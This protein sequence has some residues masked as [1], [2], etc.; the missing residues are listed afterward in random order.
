MSFIKL[1]E[2]LNGQ[3]G[4]YVMPIIWYANEHED[5]IGQQIEAIKKAG[6][7]EFIIENRDADAFLTDQW[8]N[9]FA[10]ILEKAKSLNMRVWLIDDAHVPTGS[11]NNSLINADQARFRPTNLRIE[12][13]DVVGPQIAGAVLLPNHTENEQIISVSAFQRDVNTGHCYGDPIDLR[14]CIDDDL[15][16]IDLEEGIWRIFFILTADPKIQNNFAYF[17]SMLSH[18]SCRQLVDEVY[19]KIYL[20]FPSYFGN[21]FAGFYSDEPAFGNCNGHYDSDCYFYRMG[22]T[23]RFY[24]WSEDLPELLAARANCPDQD[25]LLYLPALWDDIDDTSPMLRVA[26][27]AVITALWRDNFSRQIGTWC[28]AHQVLYIGHILEDM[29]AHFRTGF[30]CGHFFRSME[31]QHMAGLDLVLG[32]MIPGLSTI[33][34]TSNTAGKFADPKF[35]QYTLAKLGASLAHMTPSMQN[36]A[37]CEVFGAYGWTAG[38][39]VMKYIFHHFLA[40]G[41]NHFVPHAYAMVYPKTHFP[42][43]FYAEGHNPQYKLFGNLIQSVQRVCHLTADGIHK[44][45]LALFYNA[46]SEWGNWKSFRSLDD[47][48]FL[49]TR[50]GFDFDIIPSDTILGAAAVQNNRLVINQETYAALVLPMAEFLPHDLLVCLDQLAGQGLKIIFTDALPRECERKEIDLS[51]LLHRFDSIPLNELPATLDSLIQ[52]RSIR[53]VPWIPSLRFYRLEKPDGTD[54][55]LF[56]NEGERVIDTFVRPVQAGQCA[57]YDPWENILTKAQLSENGLRLKLDPHQLL[58]MIFGA[59]FAQLPDFIYDRPELSVLPLKF[60][61]YVRDAGSSEFRLFMSDSEAI[62]LTIAKHMT[63]YCGEFRYEAVFEYDNS[64]ASILEIPQIGDCAELSVNGHYCGAQ[65]G[66]VC[67]F[68]IKGLVKKGR[69][70]ISIVTAD[71]PSYADRN[72]NFSSLLPLEKHGFVGEVLIG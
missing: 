7:H 12:M 22:E 3:Y 56:A 65:I 45:D 64:E 44:A 71:N 49:L 54:L 20:H 32:Q 72:P 41:V 10:S 30:G 52:D 11:A 46:E 29:G 62:N 60:D 34:N 23:Q 16:F 33:K 51:G 40:N 31:G 70:T 24:P 50:S 63:R 36:R 8:C 67:R 48:T 61:I 28:E 15:C 4:S 39:K 37:F 53:V 69:N 66:R 13:V 6:I 9:N 55:C 26:Y 21:T 58:I 1:D 35:Y 25:I 19:E 47:V 43:S 68:K 42:P 2:C 27:M 5:Q 18:E 38:L 17:I 57:I 14:N 59:A